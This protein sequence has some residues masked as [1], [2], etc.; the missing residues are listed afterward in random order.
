MKTVLLLN[1]GKAFGESGGKLNEALHNVA[2]ETFVIFMLFVCF[3][4]MYAKENTMEYS[5]TYLPT[6]AGR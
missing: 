2:K 3:N 1:G 4:F 6:M 5:K